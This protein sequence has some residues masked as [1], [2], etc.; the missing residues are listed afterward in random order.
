M[1]SP[2]NW[3]QPAFRFDFGIPLVTGVNLAVIP[4]DNAVKLLQCFELSQQPVFPDFV[5][6]AVAD[7]D[8]GFVHKKDLQFEI[9]CGA[10]AIMAK[11]ARIA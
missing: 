7:E 11:R 3:S 4:H 6:V 10:A 1:E 8:D 5:F 2:L 9:A